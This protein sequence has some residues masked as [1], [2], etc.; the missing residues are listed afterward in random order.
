MRAEGAVTLTIGLKRPHL[1]TT[2]V[3]L[4]FRSEASIKIWSSVLEAQRILR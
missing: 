2:W 3:G 1:P 4:R